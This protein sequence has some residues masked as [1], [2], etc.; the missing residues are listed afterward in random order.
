LPSILPIAQGLAEL[1]A[2]F[3]QALA[4]FGHFAAGDFGFSGSCGAVC[5]E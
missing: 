5:D 4:E 3:L 2:G 1:V